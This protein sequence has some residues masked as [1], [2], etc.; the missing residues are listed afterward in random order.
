LPDKTESHLSY[1]QFISRDR[2]EKYLYDVT[3]NN[4]AAFVTKQLRQ[5]HPEDDIRAL[6]VFL[7]ALSGARDNWLSDGMKKDP[8][9]PISTKWEDNWTAHTIFTL[10]KAIRGIIRQRVITA[11]ICD[12]TVM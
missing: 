9:G 11:Q 7:H 6:A 3:H 10:A 8:R 1:L 2:L 12:N 4:V 5:V